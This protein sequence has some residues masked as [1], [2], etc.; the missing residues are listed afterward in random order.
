[1]NL[2]IG[3]LNK[4]TTYYFFDKASRS[5][6]MEARASEGGGDNLET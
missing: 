4:N 5:N 2:K 6:P 1:M 3:Y